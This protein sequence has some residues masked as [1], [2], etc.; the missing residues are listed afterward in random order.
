MDQLTTAEEIALMETALKKYAKTTAEK[1]DLTEQL[2]DLRKQKAEEDME[3][4]K[5]M[6]QLTLREEIAMLDQQIATYKEGTQARR[7][8]EQER[9]QAQRDLERQEYDLKVYYGQLTLEQQADALKAMIATYKEGVDA[10][11]ELEQELHDIQEE[12]REQQIDQMDG[13]IDAVTDA[14]SEKYDAQREAEKARLQESSDNWQKWGDEQTEAIQRQ[15]DALDEL[16]KNEDDAEVEAQK[17]RKIAMLEQAVAYEQDAYNKKKLMEQLAAAQADLDDWLADKQREALKASLEAQIDQVN[18]TVDEQ[19][20]AIDKQMDAVDAYYDQM[21]EDYALQQE[22]MKLIMQGG[23]ED[24]IS[25]L[26]TYAPEYN[27]TGQTLGEQLV[28]GFMSKVGDITD[29][30]EQFA[31]NLTAGVTA[32]QQQLASAA[33]AAAQQYYA[34][35]GVPGSSGTVTTTNVGPTLNVYF[36]EKAVYSPTEITR[37]LQRLLEQMTQY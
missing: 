7:E 30:F 26:A 32:A 15:I 2:Y 17:R 28:D 16:T 24:L 19:Q 33:S 14:L 27:A 21:T 11:I 35:Y 20:D 4:A 9:Y 10:R 29:W 1:Q 3:F 31:A 36:T 25:L 5:E 12:I 34:N 6:D 22:A 8:L 37:E 18:K 13:L 23:Q